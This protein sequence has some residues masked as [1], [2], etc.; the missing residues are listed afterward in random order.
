MVEK[1][2]QNTI[3]DRSPNENNAL[4]VEGVGQEIEV[5]QPENTTKGYEIIEEEDGGVTLDFD[6]NQKQSEGDYFANLAEFIDQDILEKLASDLQKNFEDD[7]NSRSD[8]EK[9]YKDGLDLLGFKYE[10]RSKPFAGAA[11]VTHPLL[12]EAVTQF[13]AQAYKELL[14]PGGPVRTEIMGDATLEVEQQS[15]RVKEFMNY[16]ITCEMQEFDPELDQMLFHLPLAGS[17]FKKVYYD[18][19]LERAVSKFVPAEDLVVPYFIT[20]LESCNRITHVVKMK[21]NDLRKNQVSGFYRDIELRA[22]RVN[23]SDIKEKQDEL[24]GVE[25]VSFAED[26]HN[27]LEMHV[28]LDIPGFEDMGANNKKTGIMLPY[29]VTLDEDS[30]EILSIYRNWNQ[31]DPL[32]KKKEYFTHFKFLPGLGFYG[33]GLI[34]MLGGLSRTATAALRQLVDAGTLSNLPAGF[35]ARGLRI[36]D[37]DEAINPGEWRDV[38][39]PGGNLRESLMPLPYKEPSATLFSLLGFVVDAGRRFAGVADMMMGENAGSQQQPVGT[40]MAILERGMKVMSAI[41]KRLHYAQ[42]TEFKLLAKVFADYLPANYPYKIAGGEQNI[43]QADFDERVDVIPVSDPNIFSMAQR[44]TLAQ[45]QLQLAQSNPEMHDLRE[46]YMRMYSALGVQNIEKLLPPPAEPQPQDPA[47]ENAGTL[48]G[49]PPLPF[50]EQDHSAHIRAHRAFMSSELVK[51]NPATMTILQA[52]ISEHVGFMARMIVQEEMAPEM[53]QIMQQSGGQLTQEQQQ[54]LAQRTE[55]GVSIKIAEITE[56]MVAEEQEMMDNIGNDPLVDLKQQEI[57]LRKD[58]L[59]LKAQA[60]GEKQALDEKKLMQTDKLTREKIES[61]EDIAQLRA[62]VALDK[63]DKDRNV[64][65]R[66]DN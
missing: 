14:P 33:F 51:A 9:T 39:A 2:I 44:V 38:D 13:Q 47:I 1:R 54:E 34:H 5:P 16:Q 64:K 3:L 58:D 30:G 21:H 36:R 49:M 17:A 66:R 65:K 8:W 50:P 60:M 63:A 59:E 24:S 26:E 35:K 42:K 32:R 45:S 55:S 7:K 18:S 31:G 61:Q 46:A 56:Q 43:K 12:A 52:H 4:E 6:P 62:N 57:D 20:D 19:T 25:Q 27:I 53:Q 28:D 48:N 10:E 41:H 29:I 23:P 22:D 11:G 40:T 15:E 37:D